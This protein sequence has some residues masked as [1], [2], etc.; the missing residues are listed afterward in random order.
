MNAGRVVE[1]GDHHSLIAQN[2]AY[3]KL[4]DAQ[5]F[6]E[7]EGAEDALPTKEE[8]KKEE[9]EG[10]P[11]DTLKRTA[12]SKSVASS[13]YG[14]AHAEERK[15]HNLG[16]LFK[17][18]YQINKDQRLSYAIGFLGATASGMVVPVFSM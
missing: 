7:T 2:G 10:F 9:A 5:A 14:E 11:G 12:T 18:M 6:I 4:V 1:K 15:R 13:A 3:K 17:R 16:Y 8:A